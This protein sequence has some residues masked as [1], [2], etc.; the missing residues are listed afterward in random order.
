[1][2]ERVKEKWSEND[3]MN[4]VNFSLVPIV[5]LG[6]KFDLFANANESKSKKS[7]CMGMRYIAHTNTCD[8]VFGSVKE[9]LPS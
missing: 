7:L 2:Q 4:K 3:D 5:V 8:L 9:K 6:S 1:M